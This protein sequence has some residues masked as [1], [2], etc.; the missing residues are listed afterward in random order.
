MRTTAVC[1]VAAILT[2]PPWAV[3]DLL[4]RV[5]PGAIGSDNGRLL[6]ESG[7]LT[8]GPRHFTARLDGHRETVELGERFL[9]VQGGWWYRG[10]YRLAPHPDGT[11][12]EHRV[13]NVARQGRWAVPLANRFFIGFEARVRARFAERLTELAGALNCTARLE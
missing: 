12:L 5:R 6:G 13:L 4:L 8:G 9:A 3:D 11:R 7:T 1:E 10:E 2:A